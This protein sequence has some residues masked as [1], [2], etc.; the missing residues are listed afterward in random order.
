ML[1]L[2]A[3]LGQPEAERP[4]DERFDGGQRDGATGRR[5]RHAL[6]NLSPPQQTAVALRLPDCTPWEAGGGVQAD[7][8]LA[9]IAVCSIRVVVV[10]AGPVISNSWCES[11]TRKR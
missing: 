3:G 2:T 7:H 8:D 6:D 4:R 1:G 9:R 5:L 10:A 11:P